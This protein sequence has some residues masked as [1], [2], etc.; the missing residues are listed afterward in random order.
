MRNKHLKKSVAVFMTMLLVLSVIS[1]CAFAVRVNVNYTI[2]NPYEEID[3]DTWVPYKTQF[4]C[5]TNASDGYPTIS[6]LLQDSYNKDYDIVAVTD[7]GT[8]NK[9]WNKAPDLIP[10]VRLV[11]YERTE[12]AD[13]IP[14]SDEEYQAYLDGTHKTTNGA[15]RT[16][17][18]G[19]LDV[20]KGIELNMATPVA[21]C[22]LTG[23]WSDYG[24]GYA[25]VYGDYETP[26]AEVKK[27]GGVTML[28]HVGEYVYIDC[29][30]EGHE[31]QKV[32]DYYAS[33][34]AKIF[35]DN[36]GSCVGMGINSAYDENTRCDRILY[37][38]I[39][40]KTI[41][42]GVVPW[43]YTFSDAHKLE[44][45]NKAYTMVY[46]PS[47]DMDTFRTSFEN[48]WSFGVSHFSKGVEL[49]GMEEI[50]GRTENDPERSVSNDTPL[51]TRVEVDNENDTVSIEGINFNMITWVSNGNVIKRECDITDGKATI[52]LND[53]D[54]LDTPELFLRFYIVG[55][56][57][58]CY[59]QPMVLEIEGE[60]FDRVKVPVQKD[61]PYF[62]RKLVTVLDDLFF[63]N[64]EIVRYFKILALGYDPQEK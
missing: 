20:P 28:A 9:G 31:G 41:P 6:E 2:T 59:S 25:G 48:G 50:P 39:L 26:A 3:W 7:H 22:H 54:L 34:F 62:L 43:N 14:L 55:D 27:D 40:Q 13:I 29:S 4:H 63:K 1:P 12:M 42:N 37:D 21:D 61:L 52:D 45:V 17:S 58:I 24:Q 23:Y 56:N 47:F 53:T 16:K 18:N 49:N 11:K 64:S 8:I 15:V 36:K 57:G 60:E 5:H 19:M 32:D 35:I 46:M 51:V 38:Q 30:S 44:D 10:L 33:K